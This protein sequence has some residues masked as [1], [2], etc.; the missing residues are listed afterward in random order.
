MEVSRAELVEMKH[1]WGLESLPHTFFSLDASEQKLYDSFRA[2]QNNLEKLTHELKNN[3]VGTEERE[4]GEKEVEKMFLEL[5]SPYL[6]RQGLKALGCFTTYG[7]DARKTYL[8]M[9]HYHLFQNN[10]PFNVFIEPKFLFSIDDENLSCESHLVYQSKDDNI[11]ERYVMYDLFER[12]IEGKRQD[13]INFPILSLRADY[14]YFA[15]TKFA[16]PLMSL[17]QNI[18][19]KIGPDSMKE[20]KILYNERLNQLRRVQFSDTKLQQEVFKEAYENK[21]EKALRIYEFNESLTQPVSASEIV[22]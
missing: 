9:P 21:L 7:N 8:I 13:G 6:Q 12:I 3:G 19:K 5:V 1:L 2:K 15:S 16:M 22:H 10:H 20:L 17:I 18:F 14:L 11:C 4:K